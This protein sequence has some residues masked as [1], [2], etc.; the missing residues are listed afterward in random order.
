MTDGKLDPTDPD[1]L[2]PAYVLDE[3]KAASPEAKALMQE[4]LEAL[5]AKVASFRE[6]GQDGWVSGRRRSRQVNQDANPHFTKHTVT[7]G[8]LRRA[9]EAYPDDAIVILS[10]DAEG[11]GFSPL[12]GDGEVWYTPESTWS[13]E[14]H[15]MG[16]DGDG[17]TYEP[18]PGD[19]YAV[20]LDPVN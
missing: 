10:K 5:A 2:I 17:D 19:L 15:T 8:Q 1:V 6:A 20:C 4:K 12:A 14:V 7:V 18:R 3:L 11:N 9:L 16:P 13:G